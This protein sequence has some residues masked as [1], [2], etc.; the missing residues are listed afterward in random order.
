M[1]TKY[2]KDMVITKDMVG[3]KITVMNVAHGK[4][5]NEYICNVKI[6]ELSDEGLDLF[7]ATEDDCKA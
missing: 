2:P 3:L 4:E 5:F 6:R 1:K 7:D